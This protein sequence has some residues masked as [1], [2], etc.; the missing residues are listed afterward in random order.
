MKDH[1]TWTVQGQIKEGKYDDFLLVMAQLVA[2]AKSEAGTLM[3]EWTVSEDK[4]SV[5]IY[6]RYQD[7]GAAKAHLAGWNE[8]GPLFLSVVDMDKITVFSQLSKEFAQAFADPRTVFM[9]PVGGF[10]KF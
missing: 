5:Y 3:Y 10:V 2:L 1:V 6:E 8:S 9:K 7:E 4:R